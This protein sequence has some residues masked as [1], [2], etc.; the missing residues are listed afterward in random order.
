MAFPSSGDLRLLTR[1]LERFYTG[2]RRPRSL[3]EALDVE[4]RVL[5]AS[6]DTG[7]WLGVLTWDGDVQLT[8]R[9]LPVA[10]RGTRPG[11]RRAAWASRKA[12]HA[13]FPP[14]PR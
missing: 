10:M 13:S 11:E 5:N 2:V 4:V 3:A 8:G 12:V 14:S 7:E 6:L 9:G 1:V